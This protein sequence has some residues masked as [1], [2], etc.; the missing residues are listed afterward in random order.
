MAAAGGA[1][2]GAGGGGGGAAAADEE[3]E[4]EQQMEYW[5]ITAHCHG[6]TFPISAGDAT[7]RIKWLAHVAIARWDEENQQ[8]WKKLGIP[9]V[10]RMGRKDGPEVD[11]GGVIKDVLSNGDHIYVSTSLQPSE[12]Q[13]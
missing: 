13:V 8:G 11:L 3:E 6:K 1:I 7:Q 2:G 5:T 9:T 12:T 10:V 4:E